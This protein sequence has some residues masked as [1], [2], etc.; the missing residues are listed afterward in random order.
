MI[1]LALLLFIS[2][3]SFSAGEI[4]T[5][6]RVTD[7]GYVVPTGGS[8]VMNPVNGEIT[9]A[10]L[11]VGPGALGEYTVTA[12]PNT[13]VRIRAIPTVAGPPGK[14]FEPTLHLTN[15]LGSS[16]TNLVSDTD[17]DFSTGSDGIITVYMGGTLTF[18][19]GFLLGSSHNVSSSLRFNEL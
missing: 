16:A 6:I 3:A 10:S 17:I 11:C 14:V 12:T 2:P 5:V 4:L 9:P 1:G 18:T 15:N 13:I 19:A 7:F 8:C